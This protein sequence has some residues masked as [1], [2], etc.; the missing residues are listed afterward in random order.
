MT[1]ERYSGLVEEEENYFVSMTDL[2]VGMLFI[3]IIMLMAFALNFR[4][5]QDKQVAEK[6]KQA[7]INESLEIDRNRILLS[8]QQVLE[9]QKQGQI[10]QVKINRELTGA[11][12]TRDAMLEPEAIA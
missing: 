7:K 5:A 8:L 3:F 6:A 11:R 4:D 1:T 10:A 9:L 2:M 12:E